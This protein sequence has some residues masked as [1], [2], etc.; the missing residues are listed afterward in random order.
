[1]KTWEKQIIPVG[2]AAA[3][4]V[5]LIAAFRPSFAGGDMDV[6]FLIVGLVCAGLAVA[7]WRKSRDTPG[8]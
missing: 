5:S 1:M 4:L 2:L 3:S 8:N 7:A 6:T